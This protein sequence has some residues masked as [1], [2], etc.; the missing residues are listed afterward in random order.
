[1]SAKAQDNP[2][3]VHFGGAHIAHVARYG[4][5]LHVSLANGVEFKPKF[6]SE[7]HAKKLFQEFQFAMD[8]NRVITMGDGTR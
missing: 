3:E 2:N 6:P 8:N 4:K 5:M 1:M 7:E